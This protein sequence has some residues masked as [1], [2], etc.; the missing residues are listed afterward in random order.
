MHITLP[1]PLLIKPITDLLEITSRQP[2][3]ET[4]LRH[5]ITSCNLHTLPS[6]KTRRQLIINQP[7]NRRKITSRTAQ[8][9]P[10]SFQTATNEIITQRDRTL[11]TPQTYLPQLRLTA[12]ISQNLQSQSKPPAIPI[13]LRRKPRKRIPAAILLIRQRIEPIR[14]RRLRLRRKT[15][16]I[17]LPIVGDRQN[18]LDYT[19]PRLLH[20]IINLILLQLRIRNLI[21]KS[22]NPP[23]HKPIL[24]LTLRKRLQNTR[25]NTA[26]NT[27]TSIIN[28]HRIRRN[29]IHSHTATSKQ[30]RPHLLITTT[31]VLIETINETDQL[32]KIH[33]QPTRIRFML[34]HQNL[35]REIAKNSLTEIRL[36]N[37]CIP[38]LQ[39]FTHLHIIQCFSIHILIILLIILPHNRPQSKLKAAGLIRTTITNDGHIQNRLLAPP[40]Y[41]LN[42]SR[43]PTSRTRHKQQRRSNII[44]REIL[45]FMCLINN[46]LHLSRQNLHRKPDTLI[47]RHTIRNNPILMTLVKET[48]DP[49][50]PRILQKPI[51][52]PIRILPIIFRRKHRYTMK[53]LPTFLAGT[54]QRHSHRHPILIIIQR[55]PSLLPLQHIQLNPGT[56]ILSPLSCR[57]GRINLAAIILQLVDTEHFAILIEKRIR[58]IT[59]NP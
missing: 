49:D 47:M 10:L 50:T 5:P 22:K 20:T 56:L 7:L 38:L 6:L 35:R 53:E 18:P 27:D 44:D 36:L 58:I 46:P 55:H 12:P 48:A 33:N 11:H 24:H 29:A 34:P 59:H 9:L 28:L 14:I 13:H 39:R 41:N 40:I 16:L 26:E 54:G 1:E 21:R 19:I 43:I 4:T 32:I 45:T 2:P 17:R 57:G 31:S 52:L 25:L 42:H 51:K 15:Q 3:L 37:P 23:V 8:I 30:L